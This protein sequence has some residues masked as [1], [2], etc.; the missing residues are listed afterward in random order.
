MLE[1]LLGLVLLAVWWIFMGDTIM[2]WIRAPLR[3]ISGMAKDQATVK[4]TGP[5]TETL[6]VDTEA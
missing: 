4:V 2:G 1:G 3:W 5:P 6:P